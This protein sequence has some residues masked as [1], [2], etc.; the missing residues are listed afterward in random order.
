[1][2]TAAKSREGGWAHTLSRST[3]T[4][5]ANLVRLNDGAQLR[6]VNAPY[7]GRYNFNVL[8]GRSGSVGCCVLRE[9]YQQ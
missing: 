2:S 7:L 9:A 6:S 8:T 3:H 1:M 4:V 5:G